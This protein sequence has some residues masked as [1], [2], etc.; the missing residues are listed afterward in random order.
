MVKCTLIN[1][2]MLRQI[3]AFSLELL[4]GRGEG[5]AKFEQGDTA[6]HLRR[7]LKRVRGKSQSLD[8][9]DAGAAALTLRRDE[10]R[11]R[12]LDA[13]VRT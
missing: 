13:R 11:G 6:F 1:N 3:R 2:F 12:R 8:R 5:P 9:D 7:K 10:G 4:K